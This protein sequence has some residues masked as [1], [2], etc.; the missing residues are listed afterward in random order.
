MKPR[1]YVETSVISYLAARPS[2]DLVVAAHQQ[3]THDW[4]QKRDE[5]D[6]FVSEIVLIEAR[7]GDPEAA[8]RRLELVEGVAVLH[9][10]QGVEAL[11]ERILSDGSMPPGSGADAGHVAIAT[12]NSMQFLV[13][14][15]MKHIANAF[16]IDCLRASCEAEGY[17]M[18]TICTPD[19]LAERPPFDFS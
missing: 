14:W 10:D 2:R 4:W 5:F 12:V 15:N 11:I 19:Q 6:L 18:P 3:S 13:T 17:D 16:A 9:V 8:K 1:V 7:G